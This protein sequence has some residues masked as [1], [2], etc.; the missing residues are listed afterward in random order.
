MCNIILVVTVSVLSLFIGVISPVIAIKC[1]EAGL[2]M[3][4]DE[5]VDVTSNLKPV[6]KKKSK[7]DHEIE[8]QREKDKKLLDAIENFHGGVK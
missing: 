4:S 6:F 1:F 2:N 3:T 7:I 5:K 8:A